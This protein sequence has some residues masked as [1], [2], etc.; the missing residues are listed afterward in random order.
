MQH[1]VNKAAAKV[2][3]MAEKTWFT[4]H[5]VSQRITLDRGKQF[6]VEFAK[7]VHDD[8]GIKIKANTTMM[9]AD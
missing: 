7:M 8:C 9:I 1:I 4:R 3:A 5:P 6:V 2:S